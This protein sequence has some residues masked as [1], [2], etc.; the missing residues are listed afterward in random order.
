MYF[1]DRNRIEETLGFLEKE[2]ALFKKQTDWQTEIEKKRLS[3]SAMSPSNALSTREI[4]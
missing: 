1:V 3:G 2:L 4:I